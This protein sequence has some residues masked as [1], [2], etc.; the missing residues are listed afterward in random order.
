MEGNLILFAFGLLVMAF[1]FILL[2]ISLY[3]SYIR[4]IYS[5]IPRP[6]PLQ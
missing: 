6:K 1:V 5:H 2:G 3:I 4:N